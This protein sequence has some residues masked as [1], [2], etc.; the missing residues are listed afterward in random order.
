MNLFGL[1]SRGGPNPDVIA[2][3][4][5]AAA[6][7]SRDSFVVDVREAGEF[8]AGHVPGA[9]NQP[10]SSFDPRRLPSGKPVI[11]ICQAEGRSAKAL[12]AARAAGLENIRHYAGGTAG[13]KRMGGAIEG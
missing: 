8:A 3:D 13:W 10:L 4:E 11:L 6:V 5:F 2:H 12:G 1:F 9:I 7:K